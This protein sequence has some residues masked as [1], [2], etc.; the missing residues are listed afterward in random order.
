MSQFY[1]ISPLFV[2]YGQKISQKT[3]TNLKP[4]TASRATQFA[5]IHDTA[6][7]HEFAR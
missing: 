7:R 1:L 3:Q 4:D 5:T 6:L 2:R